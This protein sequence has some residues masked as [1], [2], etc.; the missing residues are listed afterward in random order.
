MSPVGIRTLD[1]KFLYLIGYNYAGL[2]DEH[3]GDGCLYDVHDD[4]L[5]ITDC[6]LLIIH[7]ANNKLVFN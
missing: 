3:T 6:W 1:P 5:L 2:K 4:W 7:S